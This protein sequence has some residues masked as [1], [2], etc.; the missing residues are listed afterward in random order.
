MA[1]SKKAFS[2]LIVIVVLLSLVVAD[3]GAIGVIDW[4]LY[5][6]VKLRTGARI[7]VHRITGY[8]KYYWQQGY[9]P[10]GA[11]Y[12]PKTDGSWIVP[13]PALRVQFQNQ[14]NKGNIS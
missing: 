7:L 4:L 6:E 2:A 1:K 9:T 3:A 14:Y 10:A 13:V 5:K 11:E 8:V 12:D